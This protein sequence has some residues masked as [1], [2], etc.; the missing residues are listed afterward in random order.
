MPGP[1]ALDPERADDPLNP[2]G[3]A[4]P[5]CILDREW[6]VGEIEWAETGWADKLALCPT[7]PRCMI[8]R[9]T[10]IRSTDLRN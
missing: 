7:L 9:F 1:R 8:L 3:R 5:S 2:A 4:E 10:A 6:D